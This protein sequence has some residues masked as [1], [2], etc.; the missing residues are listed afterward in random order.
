MVDCSPKQSQHVH[1]RR[2]RSASFK[3]VLAR[4]RSLTNRRNKPL[5][6]Q[7]RVAARPSHYR[8]S[9]IRHGEHRRPLRTWRLASRHSS[10]DRFARWRSRAK[11]RL[12]YRVDRALL[13]PLTNSIS[14]SR[15]ALTA[16]R[17]TLPRPSGP[18]GPARQ[19]PPDNVHR[20]FESFLKCGRLEHGFLRVHC[21]H[22]HFER[23]VAF[24]CKKRGI[25]SSCGARRMADD[26]KNVI[27]G[28]A[29]QEPE[30]RP[31]HCPPDE[32]F[33]DVPLRQWVISFTQSIR[34]AG[35]NRS[36]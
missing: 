19:V 35:G 34:F 33:L 27:R 36:P 18:N 4:A 30:P 31:S 1:N 5:F 14:P 24:S 13:A 8:P 11:P 7:Q 10:L 6:L 15:A 29:N 17:N 9:S 3:E 20:E 16:R 12:S 28:R 22:Y 2:R 23:L 21:D 26:C 25:C 32:V